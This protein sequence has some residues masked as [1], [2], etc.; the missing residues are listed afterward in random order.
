MSALG[1]PS[2][3][4]LASAAAADTAANITKSVRFNSGD[5]A[6]LN[7]TPS[8]TGNRKTFTF[9]FWIKKV[10]TST[11][12][13]IFNCGPY[14]AGTGYRSFNIV[15]NGGTPDPFY[16]W[17][18]SN[19]YKINLVADAAHRDDSAWYHL[20]WA[21]DTTQAT[22][23]D[24]VKLYINGTQFTNWQT[25]GAGAV[26]PAQNYETGLGLA[27][28][29]RIGVRENKTSE[30]L[31]GYLADFYYIDGTALDATS[32][33]AF[34]DSG[35]WQAAAYSGSFGTNGFHLFDF[36]NESEI[37]NDSS[38]NDNDWTANNLTNVEANNTEGIDNVINITQVQNN[39]TNQT[40]NLSNLRTMMNTSTFQDAD[41][42]NSTY[43][44]R[45]GGT[46]K[47]F[48]VKWSG[49]TGL[50]GVSVRWQRSATYNP[51]V[52]TS[53][54]GI[55]TT[56][57][58][59][60]SARRQDTFATTSTT[61]QIVFE[62]VTTGNTK[63]FFIRAIEFK[64]YGSVTYPTNVENFVLSG[65][66]DQD[67]LFDVPTNGTQSDTGAGGEVSG[68]YA[69]LNANILGTYIS[70]RSTVSNGNLEF[71]NTQYAT[72][73]STIAMSS[74]KWY[75]E[76][77]LDALASASNQVWAGLLRTSAEKTAY[78][79]FQGN[80][81]EKGVHY[82]GDNTGLNRTQSY[83]VSYATAGTC[84]GIA[85]DADA[86]SCTWY[87]NGSS[88]GSSTYNIVQGEE[89]FFSFGAYTNGAWSVN[90]GQRAFKYSAPSGYKALCT[91]NLSDPT[92]T[93][94]STAF[95]VVLYTSSSGSG[96]TRTISGLNFSP[97][98]VW[99]KRRS[100]AGRHVITDIVR[101]VNKEI[102]PNLT[103]A[104][105]TSTDGLT[106]FT[107]DGYSSGPDNGAFGWSS[108]SATFVNWAWD[109]G[110]STVSNTDG[111]ITSSVRA[112]Q[113]AGFSIV[114]WTGTGSNATIGH[115]LN[116][117]PYLLIIK[118]RSNVSDW[119]VYHN[120]VGAT[121][122]LYLQA[123]GG[124]T[125][126]STFFQNT[127]PTSS[128][129]STGTNNGV[130][131]SGG[132]FIAYCISP[133][134]GYSAVGSYVGN[135]NAD[136]PFIYTGFRPAFL[137]FV[138]TD[139][140]HRVIYDSTRNT[141]NEVDLQLAANLNSAESNQSRPVDFLSNGFKVR[142]SSYLNDNNDTIVYYAVAEN[143]FQA[144]GGLAR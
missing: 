139:G 36:A 1:S 35:V 22:E 67:V 25:G 28:E 38:G 119:V 98:L 48:A 81:P 13:R 134:A 41:T 143:P 97:D 32:F 123:T 7:R 90:F 47:K 132:N 63:G 82:W 121:K 69:T 124:V 96:R 3:L 101:G 110:S 130:S 73:P 9:A 127:A 4:F 108:D 89:Y 86:G 20:V 53:G 74:G 109:A 52:E 135:G 19:S 6:Y 142:F 117:E 126:A 107:S 46:S 68:N 125:T 16:M 144:N 112:N 94:G 61:G 34:D 11:T 105:R 45:V 120:S 26:Y 128:V 62:D 39:G 84:I 72:L 57:T 118:N 122:A 56:T 141:Y 23:S 93:D 133:V 43:G 136:G 17:D 129:F 29:M 102:F 50:T 80:A 83:G 21:V 30:F 111:S 31:D 18:Y 55:T 58:T 12:K 10:T 114:S 75:C 92:I 33:G 24:R 115:G 79:Y 71:V 15:A 104:E 2:P 44:V 91:T 76:G 64:G 78:E 42:D 138:A 54:T 5:S 87:V 77:T 14:T 60:T 40:V 137:F 113:T 99:S 65:G 140:T 8:S 59:L 103:S 70:S 51:D 49:L 66:A 131:L 85:F 100:A 88:Q 116:S 95:D 106:A 27:E 37:G